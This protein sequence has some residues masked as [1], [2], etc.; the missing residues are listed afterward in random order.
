[1]PVK[2]KDFAYL[3]DDEYFSH[4]VGNWGIENTNWFIK[5]NENNEVRKLTRSPITDEI[6][7]HAS[8]REA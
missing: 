1:M 2:E 6:E 5:A 4:L 7:R 3:S 8:K